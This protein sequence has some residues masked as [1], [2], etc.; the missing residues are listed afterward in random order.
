[1]LFGPGLERRL[2][3]VATAI[4]L[5]ACGALGMLAAD[6][7]DP[8][9]GL[10]LFGPGV[11][12]THIQ[13]FGTQGDL[14][15]PGALAGGNGIALGALGAWVALRYSE[16]RRAIDE[17]FD[18]IGVGVAAAVLILLPLFDAEANMYA[19]LAGLAVGALAGFA[20]AGM[21]QSR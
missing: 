19:G 1:V 8:S 20:A 13:P 17:E 10:L 14:S 11:P 4:L 3:T 2:G 12:T 21:R 9:N 16:T 6:A 15:I 5:V 18:T 7:I